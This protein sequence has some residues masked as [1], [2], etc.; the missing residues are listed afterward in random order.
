MATPSLESIFE[1]ITPDNIKNIPVIKYTMQDFIENLEANSKIARQIISLYDTEKY[2]DDSKIVRDAKQRIRNGLYLLYTNTLYKC[3][4]NI[5]TSKKVNKILN[6]FNYINSPLKK[7]QDANNITSDLTPI[8][9]NPAIAELTPPEQAA[10]FATSGASKGSIESSESP[11]KSDSPK[12]YV[13]KS[14]ATIGKEEYDV[15]TTFATSVINNE[16]I[17]SNRE[18]NQKVGT[19]E[20]LK[21][22]YS[23]AKYIETGDI[24]NDLTIEEINPF[25]VH[26]EGSLNSDIF[27]SI[28]KTMA[29][30][31]G[32]T[33]DYT[34][35][36]TIAL[37]DY[38]GIEFI[39][40]FTKLELQDQNGMFYVFTDK[41]KGEIFEK[42]RTE[43]NPKTQLPFTDEEIAKQVFVIE[44]RHV[45]NYQYWEDQYGYGQQLIS[46]DDKDEHI[47]YRD[48][49][50]QLI[51]Y[52]TYEDYVNNF[53]NPKKVFDNKWSLNM[54][55]T[56]DIKF[57]YT[58]NIDHEDEFHISWIR[59]SDHDIQPTE[60][61][62][63]EDKN[64]FKVVGEPY[65]YVQGIDESRNRC[66]N[67]ELVL[68]S[69]KKHLATLELN[70]DYNGVITVYDDDG[71][72]EKVNCLKNRNIISNGEIDY[73]DS[74]VKYSKNDYVVHNGMIFKSLMNSNSNEPKLA[75]IYES[76][77][78]INLNEY[79]YY[80]GYYYRSLSDN[81]STIP[82]DQT[83]WIISN[84]NSNKAS[85]NFYNNINYK[86]N[87]AFLYNNKIYLVVFRD[88]IN[89][90]RFE[91][92]I[93][94]CNSENRK[95]SL[96]LIYDTPLRPAY[97]EY[98]AESIY[99]KGNKVFYNNKIYKCKLNHFKNQSIY[100]IPVSNT[101]VWEETDENPFC[102]IIDV[103]YWKGQVTYK[104]NDIVSYN[105]T[106]YISLKNL[107]FGV[108]PG[109]DASYWAEYDW[110]HINY[111][112]EQ[113]TEVEIDTHDLKGEYYTFEYDAGG[114][115]E[116]SFRFRTSGLNSDDNSYY[117]N[118]PI[119]YTDG[120]GGDLE[121]GLLV[122]GH[123]NA[124]STVYIEIS[125]KYNNKVTATANCDNLGN[126]KARINTDDLNS[127]DAKVYCY[128]R[129]LN[130]KYEFKRYIE[131][132]YLNNFDKSPN[133]CSLLKYKENIK[134]NSVLPEIEPI[135]RTQNMINFNS[136][137]EIEH[138]LI[139]EQRDGSFAPG[140]TW[141]P[142]YT[143]ELEHVIKDASL[144]DY[145]DNL[146]INNK[147]NILKDKIIH[148]NI[149]DGI[150]Y[151]KSSY[152]YLNED[153][154]VYY[155]RNH[156][157]VY[158]YGL[159][160]LTNE[161]VPLKKDQLE[162]IQSFI[163]YIEYRDKDGN[164]VEYDADKLKNGEIKFIRYYVSERDHKR[165]EDNE[166]EELKNLYY[167]TK[168]TWTS[169]YII[170]TSD[171]CVQDVLDI[172]IVGKDYYLYTAKNDQRETSDEEKYLYTSDGFYLNT[173]EYASS[174]SI[175][176]PGDEGYED[177]D[178]VVTATFD[179]T[180]NYYINDVI[181]LHIYTNTDNLEFNLSE[182]LKIEGSSKGSEIKIKC[183]KSGQAKITINAYNQSVLV[184]TLTLD[185]IVLKRY[186]TPILSE[187]DTL[188]KNSV[189][190]VRLEHNVDDYRVYFN[191]EK[192]QLIYRRN[193]LLKFK[194]LRPAD[195]TAITFIGSVHNIDV[196][197]ADVQV[198]TADIYLNV[199]CTPR[200]VYEGDSFEI[201]YNTDADD[202]NVRITE[203]ELNVK[204][205]DS[206]VELYEGD[207]Y[208]LEY[209]VNTDDGVE[210][211]IN[212]SIE[213]E[214]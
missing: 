33:Y 145:S 41:T 141:V 7:F 111:N 6:T 25:I 36:F 11:I 40:N 213:E 5:S 110:K 105:E 96:E 131:F 10:Y 130:G 162:Y 16:Y 132:N 117:I 191:E 126:F 9:V 82:T 150:D 98:D 159:D 59:D 206:R 142:D 55:M 44:N 187:F 149:I 193:D 122:T 13:Q 148:G 15:N 188:R 50:K 180:K 121:D 113:N 17:T 74:K 69:I 103:K 123:N 154:F 175:I 64:M 100:G 133:F 71:N 163:G 108:L 88:A 38:F 179:R 93:P 14:D 85:Y 29:H 207:D 171:E 94:D 1:A 166:F 208:E 8:T 22:I 62:F 167:R 35:V 18:F 60:A 52:T 45:Y 49:A 164:V 56:S 182:G 205:D 79:T 157:P 211:N 2:S 46:F 61:N 120:D 184:R 51:Y 34:T 99:I 119:V 97:P 200:E 143:S 47:L 186:I 138:V 101:T 204:P 203:F 151:W 194:C 20:G 43:I 128:A 89:S 177:V 53:Q 127:G 201:N 214:K 181:D 109:T 54:D 66:I 170:M 139:G 153:V 114:V 199:D 155:G 156:E 28:V 24:G 83:K 196:C 31:V 95:H 160:P 172:S 67:H 198:E 65:V 176:L 169:D 37:R 72:F 90:E 21:Y 76:N 68:N 195:L 161:F 135:F 173:N 84:I 27:N 152:K 140:Q 81:N 106:N 124:K 185:L 134:E 19:E 92:V 73:W 189:F 144:E 39:Y 136:N 77:S 30:P 107:N 197:D 125:D 4:Q 42:F 91:N 3:L 26:Y 210:V 178:P 165:Y 48:E 23:F 57:L 86:R 174:G 104:L 116:E 202:I 70:Q 75:P 102:Y 118:V 32:W 63:K 147:D 190:E 78:Y 192:L 80:K 168:E 115:K 212:N 87:T 129:K 58:D 137:S 146:I 209:S 183:L 12:R 112:I 158:S